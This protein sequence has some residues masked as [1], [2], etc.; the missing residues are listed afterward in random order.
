MLAFF[1]KKGWLNNTFFISEQY[2]T[3]IQDFRIHE[4]SCFQLYVDLFE[5][6]FVFKF[7]NHWNYGNRIWVHLFFFLYIYLFQS[8]RI[9]RKK[10][11]GMKGK[12]S[13][14]ERNRERGQKEKGRLY[15]G[16]PIW[17]TF[18]QTSIFLLDGICA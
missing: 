9:G 17:S 18:L 15:T 8:K 2:L 14:T 12:W 11:H 7:I 5:S 13:K 6:L 16:F 3:G 10:S 1:S 4:Y